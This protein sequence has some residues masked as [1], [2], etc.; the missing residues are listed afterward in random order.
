MLA[1]AEQDPTLM[2]EQDRA[3]PLLGWSPAGVLVAIEMVYL[4]SYARYRSKPALGRLGW[5]Q[6]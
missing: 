1:H 4:A 6:R 5:R 3:H 2:L